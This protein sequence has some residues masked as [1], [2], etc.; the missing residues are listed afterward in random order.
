M[1]T[2]ILYY[3]RTLS[4]FFQFI[5]LL[6]VKHFEN[7]IWILLKMWSFGCHSIKF[8]L[9]YNIFWTFFQSIDFIGDEYYMLG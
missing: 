2:H 3:F 7:W 8:N 6:N 1:V 9:R 4:A 5:I